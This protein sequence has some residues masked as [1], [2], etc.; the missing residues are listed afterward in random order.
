MKLYALKHKKS[1][2]YAAFSAEALD[3]HFAVSVAYTLSEAIE[4]DPIW[5]TT[6][7]E[8]ALKVAYQTCA[9][10]NAHFD[11]PVNHQAG[12][13]EVVEIAPAVTITKDEEGHIVAVT[14][15]DEDHR[16]LEVIALSEPYN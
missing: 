12:Q 5:V 2:R 11:H 10:Y 8:I 16:I 15:Q 7:R 1:G 4:G 3:D 6:D 14:R 9:I 13:W